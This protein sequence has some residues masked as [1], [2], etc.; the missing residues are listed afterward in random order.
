MRDFHCENGMIIGLKQLN[1]NNQTSL[2]VFD[3]KGIE[4]LSTDVSLKLMKG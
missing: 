4:I 3:S 2:H 1:E